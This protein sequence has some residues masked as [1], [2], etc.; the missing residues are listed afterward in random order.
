VYWSLVIHSVIQ[1]FNAQGSQ[2]P[3]LVYCDSV[4]DAQRTEYVCLYL[5]CGCGCYGC[6]GCLLELR[7][8]TQ[9][10]KNMQYK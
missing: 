4:R 8:H 7:L 3:H 9:T 10:Q 5:P 1:S 6:D 2:Q